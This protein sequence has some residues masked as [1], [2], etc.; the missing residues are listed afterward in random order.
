MITK[1]VKSGLI[2]NQIVIMCGTSV[3]QID[4]TYLHLNKETM[5]TGAEANYV[6]LEDRTFRVI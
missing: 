5:F 6:T 4:I 1:R 2:F 3:K